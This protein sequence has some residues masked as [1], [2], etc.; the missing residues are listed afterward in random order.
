M[1]VILLEKVGKLGNIGSVTEV[2]DGYARNF[3][4]PRKKALRATKANIAFFEAQ[5]AEIEKANSE[6]KLAAEAK[7]PK[8]EGLSVTIVRQAGE[9]GRLYGSVSNSD[10][11]KVI[12]NKVGEVIEAEHVLTAVK[13]KEIGTSQVEVALHPEVKA[14]I[15]LVISRNEPHAHHNA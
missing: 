7:L 9:D 15:E 4:I 8:F 6:K 1:Q 14:T 12:S 3:L 13:L 5:K 2:K 11:A 10:I